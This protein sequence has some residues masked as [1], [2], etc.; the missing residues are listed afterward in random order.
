MSRINASFSRSGWQDRFVTFVLAVL[1]ADKHEVTIVNAGHM[2][3]F[4]RHRKGAWSN[5]IGEEETGLPLGVDADYEY[6]ACTR[7]DRT[8]RFPG[9]V[10][11][12]LQR[13]DEHRRTSCTAWSVCA[14]NWPT[15][16]RRSPSWD[17]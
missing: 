4:L 9:A 11:R 16:Q 17:D 7:R 1:D 3:P 8:G 10:H 15:R 13:G 14:S 12:R 6:E 2:A 5:T